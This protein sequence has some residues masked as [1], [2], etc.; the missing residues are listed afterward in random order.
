MLERSLVGSDISQRTLNCP[1]LSIH[2]HFDA[3]GYFLLDHTLRDIDTKTDLWRSE[4]S[5]DECEQKKATAVRAR[6]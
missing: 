5:Q 6:H 4:G 2:S 1:W 3:V